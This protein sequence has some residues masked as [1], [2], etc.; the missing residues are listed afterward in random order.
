MSELGAQGGLFTGERLHAG[1]PLFQADLARHVFAYQYARELARGKRVLDAGCGDGYGTALLAEA[2]AYVVGVDR[3]ERAIATARERYQRA[4][5]S[6]HVCRLEE[7]EGLG[8]RFDL[9]CHFQVIE[10]LPDPLPF[11]RAAARVLT[12]KGQLLI[13]TPNRLL[14]RIENPYHVHE[15]VAEELHGLLTTVFPYVEVWGV[16]GNEKVMA[17][18]TERVRQAQRILRLDPLGL[19]RLLPRALVEWAYPRLARLVRRQI[20]PEARENLGAR[21]FM[22]RKETE[23]ALDLFA[24]CHCER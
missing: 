2:A 17:F 20:A 1:D 16:W 11:L 10:H 4:N 8:E 6:Y 19:R 15:Y 7:L 23:G 24:V 5:L 14:S 3:E 22:I 9:I 18:E 12:P 21:D 13:T